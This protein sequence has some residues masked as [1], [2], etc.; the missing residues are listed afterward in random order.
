MAVPE[1]V[2]IRSFAGGELSPAL[3]ARADLVK[4]T[5]GLRRCRNFQ[6]QRHGGA[7]NRP[8][9]RFVGA[10][11]TAS[12]EVALLRY[13]SEIGTDSVLIEMGVNYLRFYQQGAQI[14]VSSAPG[15]SGGTDYV[16][17]DVVDSGGTFYYCVA[18]TTGN[19]PPNA[20]FWYA[21]PGGI[22]EIPTPFADPRT[23]HWV[24]TGRVITLTHP[25]VRP[26]DLVFTSITRWVLVELET[27]PGVLPPVN[28]AIAG[29]APGARQF[30]Y[31]VTAAAPGS[32]EESEPSA[33]LIVGSVA[34]PTPDA[35]H[36]ITWDPVLTPPLTGEAS[37]EYYVYCDP[38]ANGTYGFLGT[39]TGAAEFHNPGLVP[40]FA[41]TPPLA[42]DPFVDAGDWP[43]ACA[44]HQQRRF[45]AN[46]DNTPD[47]V[48]ASRVGFPDN[49]GITSPLQDDDA[50]TFRIG[51]NN[52]HPVRFLVA[53]KQLLIFTDGGEWRLGAPGEVI[54]PNSLPLDQETYVGIAPD[55][56]PIV[57]GNSVI[58]VQARGSIV[59][60]LRFAQEVEGLA[61]RDLTIF[62][63]HLFD[64]RTLVSG[65]YAQTPHSVVWFCRSDGTLLGLTYLHDQDVW[66]WHRHD[67]ALGVFEEVRALP[68]PGEDAIYL[69]VGR[70]INGATVRYIEKLERREIL[71]FN[72]DSFF[73]D[74]G[75]SYSGAAVSNVAGLGHLEGATV[76]V[77]GDGVHLG[78]T[79]V[80]GGAITL[81]GGGSASTIHVGLPITAELETLDLDVAGTSLRDTQKRV[82]S[83]GVLL[84]DSSRGFLAGPTTAELTRYAAPSYDSP[85][86]ASHT[87]LV[88]LNL[89]SKFRV[90]GRVFLRQD[91]AL[92]VT[93]LGLIPR[94]E[95]GG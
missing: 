51:G 48:W 72:V 29:T 3:A 28:L 9:T 34:E 12:A 18:A 4:Y 22:Y 26:H 8:G 17:G 58:Y 88:E 24:Q 7:A 25:D 66:G 84:D 69:I 71:D 68:E 33:Q 40:D 37:T 76:S 70:T 41:V 38:Y 46:T 15:Y 79:V 62:A 64:G 75:L 55:V 45:L 77:V 53:L 6:I 36:T 30:A 35:P 86:N 5:T 49:F 74:S 80:V 50:I 10:C 63:S 90:N 32:Y 39:A 83:V 73:V 19:A 92:P 85:A 67:T 94:A 56:P 1:P 2:I 61:G 65:D 20:S 52:H 82:Q 21:L 93:V 14:G 42:R 87:G 23:V 59:R 13:V 27:A 95:I 60:E 11:K 43:R 78:Q 54:A 31:R 16:P 91:Q 44:Y 47:A 57:I 81:P 89:K